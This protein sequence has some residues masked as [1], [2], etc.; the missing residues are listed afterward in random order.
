[1]RPQEIGARTQVPADMVEWVV[2]KALSLNLIKGVIDQVDET[3][4]VSWVMP[5]VLSPDQIQGLV[6]RLGEWGDKTKQMEDFMVDSTAE[7]VTS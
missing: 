5:R 6:G 2:M 1:L 7:L 4:S 3:V